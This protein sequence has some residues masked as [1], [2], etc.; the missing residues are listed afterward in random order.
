MESGDVREI[1]EARG[2]CVEHTPKCDVSGG[3]G[4][5]WRRRDQRLKQSKLL[6]RI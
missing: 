4:S 6:F 5:T 1:R 3:E 2:D